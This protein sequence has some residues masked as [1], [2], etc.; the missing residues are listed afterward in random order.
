MYVLVWLEISGAGIRQTFG[1]GQTEYLVL[2]MV[3]VERRKARGRAKALSNAQS[4]LDVAK[5]AVLF[6]TFCSIG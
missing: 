6:N 3:E 5:H 1:A 4:E 2:R